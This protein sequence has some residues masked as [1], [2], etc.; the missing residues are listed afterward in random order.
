MQ[1]NKP[2]FLAT[3]LATALMSLSAMADTVD[4]LSVSGGAVGTS[5][6]SGFGSTSLAGNGSTKGE[7]YVSV[8]SL[9]GAPVQLKDVA[10]ISYWTNKPG[11]AGSPD[12]TVLLYTA[13]QN[14]GNSASWYHSRLN[15]EP[16]FV[17]SAT[18]TANAWHEW[19][20]GGAEPLKFFD[21]PRSNTFG[22]Y[23]DPTLAELVAGAVTWDGSGQSGV[24]VNYGDE[25][26]NLISLQTG[27]TWANG[28]TGMV[29]GLTITLVSGASVTVDFEAA[30]AN[31]VPEPASL[32]L[33]GVALAGLGLARRRN[34]KA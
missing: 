21:Q 12:W 4:P 22:T 18:D 15:A 2:L 32:A 14:S 34:S 29:D 25:Y 19:S 31:D 27:S 26:L 23:T 16:Y 20:T 13:L 7:Y 5:A 17:N 9:L 28:F 24:T 6:P 10:S 1:I 33:V 11:D 30:A 3:A 8:A